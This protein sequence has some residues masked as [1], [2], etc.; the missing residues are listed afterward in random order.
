MIILEENVLIKMFTL[1]EEGDYLM[2]LQWGFLHKVPKKW[3]KRL[4]TLM[5]TNHITN[6]PYLMIWSHYINKPPHT[7]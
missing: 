3:D 5:M 1:F 4:N 7:H 6:E 2:S